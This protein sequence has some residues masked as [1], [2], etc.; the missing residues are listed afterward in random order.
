MAASNA[1]AAKPSRQVAFEQCMS[2]K[3][4]TGAG[5]YLRSP[6]RVLTFSELF[7]LAVLFFSPVTLFKI[8]LHW[9][10]TDSLF[11]LCCLDCRSTR[12]FIFNFFHVPVTLPQYL[13]YVLPQ[14][15]S[16]FTVCSCLD[17]GLLHTGCWIFGYSIA[18]KLWGW[19]WRLWWRTEQGQ[20]Q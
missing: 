19:R 10:C 14:S 15:C 12:L 20:Q 4:T 11:F 6:W 1:W 9:I 18:A 13:H 5:I 3:G 2:R 16:C 17:R 7:F 8:L